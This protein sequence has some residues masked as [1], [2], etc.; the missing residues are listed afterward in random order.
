MATMAGSQFPFLQPYR[1]QI[2]FWCLPLQPLT[3]YFTQ[4]NSNESK[5]ITVVLIPLPVVGGGR[6]HAVQL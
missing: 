5:Q 6:G 1:N 3:Y 2:L 4:I